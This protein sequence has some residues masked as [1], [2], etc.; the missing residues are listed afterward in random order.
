MT[1][2]VVVPQMARALAEGL[3]D[4][5]GT[6]APLQVR[7]RYF[8][9]LRDHSGRAEELW[10]TT[11]TSAASL[12]EQVKQRYGFAL[13]SEHVRLAVNGQYCVWDTVL[14]EGDEVVFVPPVSGG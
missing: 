8:A 5:A 4:S 1:T 10:Q 11:E 2:D 14:A 3:Q 9:A 12:F 13:Q 6:A 7:I